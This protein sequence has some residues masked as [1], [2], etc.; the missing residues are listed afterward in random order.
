GDWVVVMHEGQDEPEILDALKNSRAQLRVITAGAEIPTGTTGIIS[1]LALD[2]TEHPDHPGTS[3]GALAT[4][5]LV[6]AQHQGRLWTLTRAAETDP[7]QAQT[8]GLGRVAALEHPTTWG[9]LI[10]LNGDLDPAAL[11]TALTTTAGEDQIRLNGDQI[12]GR[13]LRRVAVAPGR[14]WWTGGATLITGGTGALG[15]HTARWL[16]G[17]GAPELILTSRRGPEAPGAAELQAELGATVSIVACDITDRAQVARLIAEH[18]NIR[19]VVHAAGT[20]TTEL[21]VADLDVAAYT[22]TTA[23][24]VVGA[25]L[26]DELLPDDLDAFVVYSSISATWGSA[27]SGAYAAAN[28]HL[29]ALVR[30]RRTGTSIAWGPWAGGG[31]ADDDYLRRLGRR[32][33]TALTPQYA[34][35]ALRHTGPAAVALIAWDTF[36]DFFTVNRPSPLIQHLVTVP[37]KTAPADFRRLPVAD[38]RPHLTELVR[39]EVADVLGHADG[40]EVTEDREF[41]SLGFDSLTAV[42]LRNRLTKLT[43]LGLP[44][45]LVFDYPVVGELVTHLLEK[46]TGERAPAA[47]PAALPSDSNDTL[48]GLYRKLGLLGKMQDVESL[49]TGASALRERFGSLAE[50]GH[51]AHVSTLAQGEGGPQIVCF[52][53]FAPVDGSLQFARLAAYFRGRRKVSVVTVPGFLPG[54]PLA[55]SAEVLIEVLADAVLRAAGGRPYAVLGYSS[56]GWLAQATAVHLERQGHGPVAVV[57]LDTYLPDGMTLQMRKAMTYE[58]V[59]RRMRFTSMHYEGITALGTYRG[60]FRGWRPDPIDRPTLFVR[61]DECIPGAPEEPMTGDD[62]RAVWPLPHAE[63]NVPGDHCTMIGEYAEATGEAVEKW[64]SG[65]GDGPGIA[66][67]PSLPSIP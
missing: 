27:Y 18:P 17:Q 7:W 22:A 35:A 2:A 38:Q 57:L 54:E 45:S 5:S 50:L 34:T 12:H 29:D 32:G 43:G 30:R 4:V 46:S 44:S 8:W 59:E 55:G 56:S 11:H 14:P 64:L 39:R 28:A 13:R 47:S 36:A 58:V 37:E 51:G 60:M 41:L 61:P 26:L 48:V 24:K 1:L 15:R 25:E 63:A 49:L 23:A 52:P 53:P 21:P 42:D 31:M 9:G 20:T 65:L 66:G 33:I 62:W 40:N 3:T 16:A 10:D 19:A 6:Q 67:T